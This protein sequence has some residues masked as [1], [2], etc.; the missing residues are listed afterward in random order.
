[1]QLLLNINFV[2][3]LAAEEE[4]GGG[5]KR[6][7]PHL[8]TYALFLQTH[9]EHYSSRLFIHPFRTTS[10]PLSPCGPF[11]IATKNKSET[12]SWSHDVFSPLL[13]PSFILF[14]LYLVLHDG[15]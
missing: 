13:C 4:R 10:Y 3:F 2:S 12:Q 7:K 1:M 8:G 11:A 14:Q 9:S 5:R 6:S 15:A